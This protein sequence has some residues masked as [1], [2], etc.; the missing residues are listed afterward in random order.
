MAVPQ[1]KPDSLSSLRRK[2]EQVM[3]SDAPKLFRSWQ[4]LSCKKKAGLPETSGHFIR[5]QKQI[6][7]SLNRVRKRA[8]TVPPLS[9]PDELPICAHKEAIM[10]TIRG[11]SVVVI[12]GETGSGKTTQIPKLCLAAGRGRRGAVALTQP[13]RIAAVSIA[14]RIA[15]EI[16]ESC[17]NR[18][19][20]KIRFEEKRSPDS[21]IQVMTDGI[22][23]TEISRDPHLLDYDTI[24]LDEAHERSL[25]IDFLLGY[26][27]SLLQR[28]KDLKVVITSATID[29]AKFSQAFNSA[30][31]IEVSG[32]MY[33][34]EVRYHPVI[35]ASDK[36]GD[37]PSFVDCAVACVRQLQQE[38][39]FE[40]ILI[41]L[42]TESDIREACALLEK[43]CSGVVLPLYARLS[44]TGQHKVFSRYD[45]QK[46]VVA[47]NIAETSL[48]IPGIRYVIDSGL[49]RILEYNSRTQTTSLPVKPISQSSAD[50]RKGRCGRVRD[51]ICIRLYSEEDYNARPRFTQPEILRSNLAGVILRMLSLRLG[52][53]SAFPFVDRPNPR[54]LSDALDTLKELGALT[55][56]EQ[57]ESSDSFSLTPLGRDMSRLPVDPRISCMLLAARR[58]QC[59]AAVAVIAAFLSIADP[60]ERPFDSLDLAA[61]AHAAFEHPESD[62]LGMINLWNRFQECL[63][64]HPSRNQ[65]R[66]FCRKH[67][68]SYRRMLEWNDIYSQLIRILKQDG[69][70]AFSARE[71]KRMALDQNLADRIHRSVLCGYLSNIAV[72]KEKNIYSAAK[73]R[74][75]MLHPGSSLFNRSPSWI[76]A[77]DISRTSRL[78]ARHNSAISSV[79]LEEIGKDQCRRTYSSPHWEKNRGQVVA[80]EKVTLF[81]LTLVEARP[82]AYDKIAPEQSREIFIREA[83]IPGEVAFRPPF[84]EHNLRLWNEAK[85]MEDKLRTRGIAADEEAVFRLYDQKLPAFADMRSVLKSIKDRGGDSFLRFQPDDLL[86][87][88][89]DEKTLSRYPQRISI[90]GAVLPCRYRFSPGHDDDGITV[91]IPIGLLSEVN[92]LTVEHSFSSLMEE[93]ITLLIKLLPKSIRLKLPPGKAIAQAFLNKAPT[94]TNSLARALSLY[95]LEVFDIS[96]PPEL[97]KTEALPAHLQILFQAVDEK[98]TPINESRNIEYLE[99]ASIGKAESSSLE[100]LKTQW[101]RTGLTRWDFDILPEKIPVSGIS[102]LFGHAYPALS[103]ENDTVSVRLFSDAGEAA[104]RHR[105]GVSRLYTLQFRDQLRQLR[106]NL[107][108]VGWQKTAAARLGIPKQLEEAMIQRV[109]SDLFECSWRNRE[110]FE[111]HARRIGSSILPAGQKVLEAVDPVLRQLLNTCQTIDRLLAANRSIRMAVVFLENTLAEVRKLLPP[112]FPMHYPMARLKEIPRYLKALSL[113][114]ERSSHNIPSAINKLED[115]NTYNRSYHVL[116]ESLSPAASDEKKLKIDELFWMIQEYKVSVFAQELKTSRKVSS[117]ILQQMIDEISKMI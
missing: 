114:A 103:D 23:L 17:G 76:V 11:H 66:I 38:R 55:R 37:E 111:D 72:K 80:F 109:V 108:L 5:L 1:K 26:L 36:E 18:I 99:R 102:G 63:E 25:N 41:F 83:L 20:Y 9:F 52:P 12:S 2:L 32:R 62:F 75:V 88:P 31:V 39:R 51:G 58:E 21:L 35:N 22:L 6:E 77:A 78:F 44:N 69:S 106:K 74:E 14:E 116:L 100:T 117:K 96:V 93:K 42:P 10:E 34:V 112:D 105:A 98:G 7:N 79:W 33:P 45:R 30:P 24:I 97:W 87:N 60:R 82:A 27:H 29:T 50:Q 4:D 13:R 28:R 115:I 113:R 84:L 49:A 56:S 61:A 54:S 86:V 107:N 110:A 19:A 104:L 57:A 47:T 89:P 73:S 53:I 68:L 16:G 46:I 101:E 40:D 65:I 90:A 92:A 59:V 3:I 71:E 81:G 15:E 64:K 94:P 85:A 95:I 70:V 48:T 67:Y 91:K 8:D 43:S